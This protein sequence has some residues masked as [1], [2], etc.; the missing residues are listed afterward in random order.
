MVG[1][2]KYCQNTKQG[3]S[4]FNGK[5]DKKKTGKH[6]RNINASYLKKRSTTNPDATMFY[7]P[8]KGGNLSYKA[9]ISSEQNGFI[10]AVVA[11]PSALRDTGAVPELIE[12]HEKV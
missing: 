1:N 5:I 9:H 12:M 11:S 6:R 7:R 8:N 2:K 3:G 4:H 10:T